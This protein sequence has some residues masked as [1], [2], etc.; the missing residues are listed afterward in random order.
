MSKHQNQRGF[1]LIEL[2]VVIAVIGILAA[3]AIPN[4]IASKR[5]ANESSAISGMRTITTT[6][7]IYQATRGNGSY[8]TLDDLSNADLLIDSVLAG[9]NTSPKNGYLYLATPTPASDGAPAGY[10]AGARPNMT[11]TYAQTGTRRF[12]ADAAGIIYYDRDIAAP[13]PTSGFASG[14]NL[15]N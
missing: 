14:Q 11:G 1:S 5:A 7:A 8:G 10:I 12:L 3:L 2:L 4:L 6:E 9:A 13:I 15:G